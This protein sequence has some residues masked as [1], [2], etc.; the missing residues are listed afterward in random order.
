MAL[1]SRQHHVAEREPA[2][3]TIPFVVPIWQSERKDGDMGASASASNAARQAFL[4]HRNIRRCCLNHQEHGRRIH[5]I[6]G[7]SAKNDDTEHEAD[8]HLVG[9]GLITARPGQALAVTVA[10]CLPLFLAAPAAQVVAILHSGRRSTG[11]LAEAVSILQARYAIPPATLY[12]YIGAGIRPCCYRVDSHTQHQFL[13]QLAS[14]LPSQ[15][16]ANIYGS[17]A[18]G[19]W[20]DL[21]VANVALAR[22]QGITHMAWDERC[23]CCNPHLFSYRKEGASYGHMIAL[24]E[25]RTL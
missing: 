9:D 8:L 3:E 6:E 23:S 2:V 11:I 19:C 25:N 4:A 10:D 5:I 1:S 16:L 17:D 22:Q 18:H 24:I 13:A 15:Q 21:R 14:Y 7:R 20:I 12:L